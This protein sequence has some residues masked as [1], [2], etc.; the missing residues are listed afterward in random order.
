MAS[1][2][3]VTSGG[4][5]ADSGSSARATGPS[6]GAIGGLRA[7]GATV[8]G[9]GPDTTREAVASAARSDGSLGL[10]TA[11]LAWTAIGLGAASTATP[12]SDSS[13]RSASGLA[14]GLQEPGDCAVARGR[15]EPAQ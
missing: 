5:V 4:A 3:G 13:A 9:G 8:R 7:I 12:D 14:I 6:A 15:L 2:A 10:L 11:S 1:T